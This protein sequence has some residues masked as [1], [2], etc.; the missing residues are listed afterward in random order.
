M[1]IPGVSV[2]EVPSVPPAV[3]PADTA[4]PVFIGYTEKAIDL[5]GRSLANVPQRIESLGNMSSFSA[6]LIG[7]RCTSTSP[8]RPGRPRPPG[9]SIRRQAQLRP[10]L[11]AP[12]FLPSF[13]LHYSVALFYANGGRAC[14]VLSVGP[15]AFR[16]GAPTSAAPR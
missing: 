6:A 11:S 16:N 13:L 3:V 15:Y 10:A 1:K 4:I 14:F 5:T 9:S 2:E 8:R 12:F 7:R